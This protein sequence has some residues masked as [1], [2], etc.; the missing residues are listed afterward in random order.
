[1]SQLFSIDAI[2]MSPTSEREASVSDL[3][4]EGKRGLMAENE[5]VRK[6]YLGYF[7][8]FFKSSLSISDNIFSI[9]NY[10]LTPTH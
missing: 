10:S 4:G 9:T 2:S 3:C 7:E 5:K 8:G 6:R 1:M